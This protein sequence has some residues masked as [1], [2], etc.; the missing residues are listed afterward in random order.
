MAPVTRTSANTATKI[1]FI[2][3]S[4]FLS[5]LKF[6]M[7]IAGRLRNVFTGAQPAIQSS[8]FRASAPHG[9]PGLSRT[10]AAT[11]RNAAFD[12]MRVMLSPLEDRKTLW[13]SEQYC[14][15]DTP[16]IA[17]PPMRKRAGAG[18]GD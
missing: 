7:P 4:S 6:K 18:S 1:F 10:P 16:H 3:L 2:S 9:G 5:E 11:S 17:F 15:S 12:F 8:R 13:M 14:C